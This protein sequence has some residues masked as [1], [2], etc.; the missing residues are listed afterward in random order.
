[1]RA[2]ICGVLALAAPC[3]L[4]QAPSTWSVT[5]DIPGRG[6]VRSVAIASNG[7]IVVGGYVDRGE[8]SVQ[9]S[10]LDG[11]LA[12]YA[13][14]GQLLWERRIGGEFRDEVAALE[15]APDGSIFVAGPR[16]VQ[17]RQ[18][19]QDAASYVS[20]YAADG[21]LI[22][23]TPFDDPDG[24]QVW[25]TSLRLLDSGSL[26]VAGGKKF[27][28]SGD[29]DAY[30]AL[31]ND[32]GERI[33]QQWPA[34]Y[35][36]GVNPN[37]PGKSMTVRSASGGHLYQ[38]HGRL[39]RLTSDNKIELIATQPDMV[40]PLAAR[41]IVV[42]LERGHRTEDTC[43]PMNDYAMHMTVAS[44]PF[45]ASRAGA[46][47]TGDGVVRKYDDAGN[48]V[49][50]FAPLSD[51]GD[52]FNAAAPT[53]DGGVVVV[54]YRLHGRTAERHNWDGVL[55]R[56]DKYGNE[57]WRREFDAGKRDEL[58]DLALLSDGSIIAVGYTTPEGSD[59]WKPWIMRLN[60][61]GQLE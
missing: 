28:W 33:W 39:S 4:A 7:D 2:F 42:E 46:V 31:V 55:V 48:V 1:M 13:P 14:N 36:D 18:S 9:A 37:V 35:P 30:I 5:L 60:P 15:I 25:L 47:A 49:W 56:L 16:D 57:L 23:S 52:G 12:R 45:T 22:W 34:P 44:F 6:E 51:D 24:P 20:R 41:C 11:L 29:H 19:I 10:E 54:G 32:A 50:E 59:I 21:S 26:L 40:G 61:E 43:G 3:A 53:S 17:L 58:T 27:S 8:E 38:E